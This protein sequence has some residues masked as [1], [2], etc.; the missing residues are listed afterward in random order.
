MIE[1]PWAAAHVFRLIGLQLGIGFEFLDCPPLRG[2][3]G[4]YVF[5]GDR[6]YENWIMACPHHANCEKR[7]GLGPRNIAQF[8]PLEPLAFLMAW[9]DQHLGADSDAKGHNRSHPTSAA[10]RDVFERHGAD[11]QACRDLFPP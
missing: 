6:L 5:S 4:K 8:G 3:A 1:R 9:R 2:P 7:R 11:L 10:V